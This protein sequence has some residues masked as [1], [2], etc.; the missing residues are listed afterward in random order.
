MSETAKFVR[1]QS[2]RKLTVFGSLDSLDVTNPKELVPNKLRVKPMWQNTMIE[3]VKGVGY[4]PA[5]V[6]E[7]GTIKCLIADKVITLTPATQEEIDANP[8]V[9]NLAKKLEERKAEV[10]R[11]KTEGKK[12]LD[13]ISKE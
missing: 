12:T 9:L 13:E 7:W 5:E 10:K 6:A 8:E 11:Q 2:N 3:L 1:I 4:Y